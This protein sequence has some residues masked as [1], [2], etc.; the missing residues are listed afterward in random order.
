MYRSLILILSLFLFLVTTTIFFDTKNIG[1]NKSYNKYNLQDSIFKLIGMSESNGFFTA[2]GFVFKK[3]GNRTFILTNDHFCSATDG[4]FMIQNTEDYYYESA[5]VAEVEY[6]DEKYDLCIASTI[7][8]SN[9]EI[10]NIV[11]YNFKFS[12]ELFTVG[13][14]EGNYPMF[15]KIY[16]SSF[17]S[18]DYIT[19]TF[20]GIN[21]SHGAYYISGPVEVGQSG[22][23]VFNSRNDVVG[24]IFAK[25]GTSTG[26]VISSKDVLEFVGNYF[27]Y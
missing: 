13:A 24:V 11:D 1:N 5:R 25:T 8:E 19:S 21:L 9:E 27:A 18:K 3:R 2:T 22:S 23:P 10:L 20:S 7:S 6:S 14:P 17:T 16:F 26:L 4:V 12:E 15:Y